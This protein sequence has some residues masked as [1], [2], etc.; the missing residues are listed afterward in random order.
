MHFGLDQHYEI[1]ARVVYV[2]PGAYGFHARLGVRFIA[3]SDEERFRLDNFV[4]ERVAASHFGVRS[5][6]QNPGNFPGS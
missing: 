1:Q 3:M 4:N 6:P 5:F 2:L